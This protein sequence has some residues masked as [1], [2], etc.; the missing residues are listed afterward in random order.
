MS[1][2]WR[3]ALAAALGLA[4]LPAWAA[5]EKGLSAAEAFSAAG[6]HARV[7]SGQAFFG[8]GRY[9][10]SDSCQ[11]CHEPQYRSWRASW[12][13]KMERWPGPDT[14]V[15][16]FDDRR[17]QFRKLRVRSA[18]DR[19]AQIDPTARTFRQDGRYLFTLF[20]RDDPRND[21][22]WEVAKVIGGKWDQ[23][24]EIRL[25]SDNYL[26]APIRWSV[27]QQ[28]W[29]VG[30]FNP[31]DWFVADGTPDGR[32]RRPDELPRHR[33]AEAKCNG[34]HTTGYRYAKG[35]EGVWKA[36]AHGRG[37]IAVACESCHGPGAR[38]VDEAQ[39]AKASGRTLKAGHTAIV[40]PLTDLGAEQATQVCGQC[41]GRGS[42][43]EQADLAFPTNFLPGDTDLTHRFRLWSFSGT[44]NAAESAYFWP[45]DWAA[46]NRQ[47]Y[48][49]FTKS[50]HYTKAGLSC[51]TCHA[52]HG[53][54]E[55]AQLREAPAQICIGCHR[56]DGHAARPQAEMFAHSTKDAAGVDCIDCHMPRIAS[57]SRATA[58]DGHQ[59]DTTSHVFIVPT[60]QWAQTIGIRDACTSCHVHAPRPGE[61]AAAVDRMAE[62]LRR[63]VDEVRNGIADT[64]ARLARVRSEHPE[65]RRL[66]REAR[67]RLDFIVLDNS[68]GAHNMG[69]TR[70]LLRESQALAAQAEALQPSTA[71]AAPPGRAR[72]GGE[73]PDGG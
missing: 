53:K 40:N 70:Q 2:G 66:V 47:Q 27:D 29:I 59:W 30:G 49:D 20:D 5:G 9:A 52:F 25:G 50:T 61:E 7:A 71:G 33:V 4:L 68:K 51:V 16:D 56:Q 31:Q 62:D 69:M 46:R 19:E 38:H 60:P 65:A 72:P 73:Q 22:T 36:Q 39:T 64:A 42:H 14:V 10:G 23:G 44:G 11:A 8:D 41:H 17:I 12:H 67:A 13:S 32:P 37:E 48:Q 28:D 3:F 45:N 18:D 24:Y 57:R 54:T 21:Q 15:G 63:R 55:P 1:R 58:K 43:K 34:C 26:P 6:R 35:A